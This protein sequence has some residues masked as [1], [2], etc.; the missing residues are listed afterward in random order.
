MEA[1]GFIVLGWSEAG[2]AHFFTKSPVR[3]PDDMRKLKMFV[4]AGDDQYAELWKKA[5]FN[6]VPLPSTEIETA[7]QTGLVNAVTI[8]PQGILLLQ[9]YRQVHYMTDFKWA[10]V[11]GGIA[12]S[13]STWEKIP[14]EIR[15]AMRQAA[16]KAAQRLRD[17]SRQTDQSDVE[18]LKKN[19]VEVVSVDEKTLDEWR[20]LVESV[21]T[22]VRGS[23]LPAESLDT[24][25]KLRDQ[26]GRQ[27][28]EAGK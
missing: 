5:G 13:K 14:A 1:Q 17:F 24:A 25:L 2:W 27:A 21:L 28:G 4:W 23:Y 22:Q 15:P 26:C 11:L 12:I 3:T 19:G 10:V 7:L 20:R 8:N 9:W 16:L 18:A 6:S